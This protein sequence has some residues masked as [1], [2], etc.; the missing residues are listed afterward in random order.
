M[1][2]LCIVVS[3]LEYYTYDDNVNKCYGNN[4]YKCYVTSR[5][6]NITFDLSIHCLY[7][8]FIYMR[9]MGR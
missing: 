2:S 5:L 3:I 7:K 4:W 6:E 9:T 8:T 1:N